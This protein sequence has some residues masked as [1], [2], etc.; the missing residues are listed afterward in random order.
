MHD[1][2]VFPE[3]NNAKFSFNDVS[4]SVTPITN[5]ILFFGKWY[6]TFFTYLIVFFYDTES[7]APL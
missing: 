4:T 1:E 6:Q 2:N 3:G 7:V 5:K